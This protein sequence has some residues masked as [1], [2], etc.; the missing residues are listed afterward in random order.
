[1]GVKKVACSGCNFII[2]YA[3][4]HVKKSRGLYIAT[5][6]RSANDG[7]DILYIECPMCFMK[8]EV[9]E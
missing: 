3:S 6:W 9:A 1:M 5:Q 8:I 2:E 4:E 7:E